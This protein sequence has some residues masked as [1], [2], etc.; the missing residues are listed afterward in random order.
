MHSKQCL[1][2]DLSDYDFIKKIWLENFGM[3]VGCPMWKNV[4]RVNK[5]QCVYLLLDVGTIVLLRVTQNEV[6][7]S[8]I[9]LLIW[10]S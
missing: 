4:A 9:H 3:D 8:Y 2:E 7:L 1:Y 6:F 10:V 5:I